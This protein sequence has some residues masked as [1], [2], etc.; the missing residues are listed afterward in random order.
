[1]SRILFITEDYPSGLNGN[2]VK[3]R[4]TLI[5]LLQ[6]KINVDL[7]CVYNGEILKKIKSSRLRTFLVKKKLPTKF[8]IKN[9]LRIISLLISAN[10][11][12]VQRLFEL[13][14]N[15]LIKVLINSSDYDYVIYDGYSTLI[16]SVETKSQQ[17]YIDDEDITD[18]LLKRFQSEKHLLK[19]IQGYVDYFKSKLYEKKYLTQMDQVWAIS[20]NTKKRLK[21]LTG[22]KTVL[23]PTYIPLASNVYKKESRDIIFTGTLSWDENVVGLK[24]FLEKHWPLV[25]RSYPDVVLHIVGREASHNFI[26]YLESFPKVKYWGYVESLKNIYSNCAVAVSP[27]LINAGIKVKI[28]TYLKYGLPVV[29]TKKSTLG[30]ISNLGIEIASENNFGGKLVNLLRHPSKRQSLSKLGY[31]NIRQNYAESKLKLFLKKNTSFV[32]K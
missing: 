28:L 23:M 6:Q 18:L 4:N 29:A 10:P 25:H 22:A 7:C 9:I 8:S 5:F 15:L 2:S 13:E 16:H 20:P 12:F 26:K 1:M 24:W 30:L 3:T 27:V 11:L 31:L 32:M 17:I 19:K 21:T 14:L